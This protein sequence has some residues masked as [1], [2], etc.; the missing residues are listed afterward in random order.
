MVDFWV[1]E[2]CRKRLPDDMLEVADRFDS[3]VERPSHSGFDCPA[4]GE[5]LPK[6]V[7]IREREDGRLE[8]IY[9]DQK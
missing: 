2:E 6:G 9:P 5:I 3:I 4:F 1:V 7:T 8:F